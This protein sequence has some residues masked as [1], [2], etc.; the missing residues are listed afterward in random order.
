MKDETDG[1]GIFAV[2]KQIKILKCVSAT[3]IVFDAFTSNMQFLIVS[4][5]YIIHGWKFSPMIKISYE[6]NFH[7]T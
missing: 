6:V 5:I 1:Y 7:E 4:Y 2:Y 3:M